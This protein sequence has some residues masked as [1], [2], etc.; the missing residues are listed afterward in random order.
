MARHT[1]DRAEAKLR[2]IGNCVSP[3]E[4]LTVVKNDPDDDRILECAVAA[5]SDYDRIRSKK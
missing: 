4:T 2:S 5:N 1:I 3:T